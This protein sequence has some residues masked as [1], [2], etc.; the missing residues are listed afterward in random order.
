MIFLSPK[1]YG[2]H[3]VLILCHHYV[4]PGC[5]LSTLSKW[6]SLRV[7]S[8][9]PPCSD[10]SLLLSIW[11]TTHSKHTYGCPRS[12]CISNSSFADTTG[13]SVAM[14]TSLFL[15]FFQIWRWGDEVSRIHPGNQADIIAVMHEDIDCYNIPLIFP[16]VQLQYF[17]GDNLLAIWKTAK[18]E[19]KNITGALN[20]EVIITV[21]NNFL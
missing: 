8:A 16:W 13:G 14:L 18:K 2:I 3:P 4:L 1:Q 19:D 17:F 21:L 6:R 11:A 5:V 7:G 12:L 10:Q 20:S 9:D 15:A